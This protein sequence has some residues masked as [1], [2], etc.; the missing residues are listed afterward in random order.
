MVIREDGNMSK[1]SNK[2]L[3][4]LI[5]S[6]SRGLVLENIGYETMT[7]AIRGIIVLA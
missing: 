3:I 1:Y 5:K 4:F 6:V 7:F 2:K